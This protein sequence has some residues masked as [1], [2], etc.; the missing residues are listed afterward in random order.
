MI[1][2]TKN[3]IK[4]LKFIEEINS[5]TFQMYNDFVVELLFNYK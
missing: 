1:R 5:L 2:T 4:D 3:N